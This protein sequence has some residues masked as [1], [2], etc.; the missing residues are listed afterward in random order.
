MTLGEVKGGLLKKNLNISEMMK[1]NIDQFN[2]NWSI[3]IDAGWYECK[4]G[5]N[6]EIE[7]T[8]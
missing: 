4:A 1:N 6:Y 5:M 3:Y 2:H 8:N 7:H